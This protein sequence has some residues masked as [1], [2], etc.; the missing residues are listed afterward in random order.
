MA[1]AVAAAQ[2]PP[3]LD[4]GALEAA[5]ENLAIE[6]A[7]AFAD[8][9]RD[10]VM[11]S[12]ASA[13]AEGRRL[14]EEEASRLSAV[15]AR[16]EE[17]RIRIEA[18]CSEVQA[19]HV[20][21]EEE[22]RRLGQVRQK[23]G[24]DL[25]VLDRPPRP[26]LPPVCAKPAEDRQQ[27]E[28]AA[29]GP[30]E[31]PTATAAT[32]ATGLAAASHCLQLP[33]RWARRAATDRSVQLQG[34]WYRLEEWLPRRQKQTS[35]PEQGCM[36]AQQEENSE[37]ADDLVHWIPDSTVV[38][39][40]KTET[41]A[42]EVQPYRIETSSDGVPS[43]KIETAPLCSIATTAEECENNETP[44]EV[45]K[46]YVTLGVY[47]YAV[48]PNVQQDESN[49]LQDMFG[50]SVVVPRGWEVLSTSVEGFPSIMAELTE[51][52]WGTSLLCVLNEK[53]RF[54]S[55]RTRLYTHGGGVGEL[56]SADSSV[57]QPVAELPCMGEQH[58]HFSKGMVLSGRLVIRTVRRSDILG[59][60]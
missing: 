23:L 58:Y 9:L 24:K 40:C 38:R 10:L 27:R 52:G 34:F 37:L 42:E 55:Y 16:F 26:P 20:H 3:P 54:N 25:C 44:Q 30:Q 60:A 15:R 39:A 21:L 5:A 8:G 49:V 12:A 6:A 31:V 19:L 43:C 36:L 32:R 41:F 17:E 57:L 4:M 28:A 29:S 50:T 59:G 48:L 18:A 2:E 53:R 46:F 51:H 1:A 14:A 47:S 45:P 22:R 56:L 11:R 7:R 33:L 35:I 13:K